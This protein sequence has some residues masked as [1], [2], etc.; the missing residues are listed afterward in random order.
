MQ[1]WEY[2]FV[3]C[4]IGPDTWRPRF[5]NGAPLPDW[6]TGTLV[7]DFCNR[8]GEEGWEIV[9]SQVEAHESTVAGRVSEKGKL[10]ARATY[11]RAWRLVFKRPRAE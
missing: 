7:H 4:N 3:D 11:E 2:L 6:E 10:S 9:S 5:A 8:L 1:K